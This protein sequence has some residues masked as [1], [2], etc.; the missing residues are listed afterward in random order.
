MMKKKVLIIGIIS[1]LFLLSFNIPLIATGISITKKPDSCL[2]NNSDGNQ[3]V[4]MVDVP[5]LEPGDIMFRYTDIFDF[6]EKNIGHTLLYKGFN[7]SGTGKYE[8]IE[9]WSKV[10]SKSYSERGLENDFWNV[11]R[12]E[13]ASIVQKQ[14]AIKFAESQIGK[15]FQYPYNSKNFNPNDENDNDS[16]KWYCS[17]IVWAA[18]YNCNH[19]PETGI[20]GEGI[21]IDCDGW[22][23]KNDS[24]NV[25]VMPED[26]Y[27]DSDVKII[28]E[29][30]LSKSLSNENNYRIRLFSYLLSFFRKIFVIG[31]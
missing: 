29:S 19:S 28:W 6:E 17:E 22:N 24:D 30:K 15:D 11:G 23:A 10:R 16:D 7:C 18:Y 3:I 2:I 9:A 8:F 27:A 5:I 4:P 26:I 1:L 31:V 20:L 12:V 14:N 25:S 13:H 21:D